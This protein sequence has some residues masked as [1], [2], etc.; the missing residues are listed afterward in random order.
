MNGRVKIFVAATAT[1]GLVIIVYG[2]LHWQSN[3]PVRFACYLGIAVLASSMKVSLPG[4]DGTMSVN[5]LFILMGIV[6]L[7]FP[8]TLVLGCAATF[9][10]CYWRV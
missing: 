5:F 6:E 3:D 2:L 10:Q 1:V 8:E 4:I 7:S 9:T